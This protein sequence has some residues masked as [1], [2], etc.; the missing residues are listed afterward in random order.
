MIQISSLQLA[1]YNAWIVID[2]NVL[3]FIQIILIVP[4]LVLDD[5]QL[6]WTFGSHRLTYWASTKIHVVSRL[7]EELNDG[8]N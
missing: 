3:F 2:Y 7:Y 8:F 4:H 5:H 6:W 1:C